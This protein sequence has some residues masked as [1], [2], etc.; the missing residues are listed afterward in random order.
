MNSTGNPG[1][2]L[3]EV[4]EKL[5]SPS[6]LYLPL[7]SQLRLNETLWHH[8]SYN[9][10]TLWLTQVG[11]VFLAR[12]RFEVGFERNNMGIESD[13]RQIINHD[14]EQGQEIHARV[15]DLQIFDTQLDFPCPCTKSW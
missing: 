4:G 1:K 13:R 8:K 10:V 14:F 2:T 9:V 12:K 5:S 6:C 7:E 15:K 11:A 3:S